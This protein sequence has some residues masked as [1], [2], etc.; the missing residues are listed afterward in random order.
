MTRL[1]VAPET[2]AS[3]APGS[4]HR[5]RLC[6]H[7]YEQAVVSNGHVGTREHLYEHR[8]SLW[9]LLTD[10]SKLILNGSEDRQTGPS[11]QQKRLVI[12]MM[13]GALAQHLIA[14]GFESEY[15]EPLRRPSSAGD[16]RSS[17]SL[18]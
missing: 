13:M 3:P 17:L 18:A 2:P 1:G 9:R 16:L 11:C 4:P 7:I 5:F 6:G 12:T 14:Q 10:T 8:E 15:L